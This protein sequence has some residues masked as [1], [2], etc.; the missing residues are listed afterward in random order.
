MRAMVVDDSRAMR[1]ILR[2]HLAAIGFEVTAE[3]ANG[4]DALAR[5][6]EG[7]TPDLALVDWNMPEMNGLEF[8]TALRTE[9]AWDAMRVVMV[10]TETEFDNIHTAL[11]AGANEYLMKPFT[12]EALREKLALLGFQVG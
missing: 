1:S 10:T 11:A 2:K 7:P 3:G 12:E 4:L 5:L 8:V 6:R 9:R